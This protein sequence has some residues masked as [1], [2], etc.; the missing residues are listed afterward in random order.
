MKVRCVGHEAGRQGYNSRTNVFAHQRAVRLDVVSRV[1]VV[2]VLSDVRANIANP[3]SKVPIE[4]DKRDFKMRRE[5]GA[6]SALAG[7]TGA[8]QLNLLETGHVLQIIVEQNAEVGFTAPCC[9]AREVPVHY[10]RSKPTQSSR[11]LEVFREDR[12]VAA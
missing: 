2:S 11:G 8:E 6:D 7:S 10:N 12:G 9:V 5:N 3:A 4:V 1:R